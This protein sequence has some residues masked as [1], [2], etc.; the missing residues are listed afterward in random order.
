L[1]TADDTLPPRA[2]DEELPDGPSAGHVWHRNELVADYYRARRWNRDS[3]V[4]LRST[5]ADLNLAGVADDLAAEGILS[6]E[7]DPHG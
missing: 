1:T 6:T 5:L 7:K 4:P 3:G 2:R